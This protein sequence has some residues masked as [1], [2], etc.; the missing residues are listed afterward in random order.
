M[1]GQ[2]FSHEM[3][4]PNSFALRLLFAGLGVIFAALG[5]AGIFLPVLPATPFLLLSAACFARASTRVYNWLLNHTLF[6][7]L[8]L[9]WRR[10]R[11]MPYRT[12]LGALILLA[13]SLA[14]S[15]TLFLEDWRAQAVLA[16]FGVGLGMVLWRIPSRDAPVHRK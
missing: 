14:A 2:D 16:V 3:Q 4:K 1:T 15:I 10:H 11:A 7:P 8:I 5:L 6:G 13:V 9:E 12:K